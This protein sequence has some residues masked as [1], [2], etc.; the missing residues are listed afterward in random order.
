MSSVILIWLQIKHISRKKKKK[1]ATPH[2]ENP[3]GVAEAK[4]FGRQEPVAKTTKSSSQVGRWGER[5]KAA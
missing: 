2:L 4:F 5:G 3:E 1:H